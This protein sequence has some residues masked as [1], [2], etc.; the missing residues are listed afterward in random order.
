MTTSNEDIQLCARCGGQCCLTRP[1]I[2]APE[3]FLSNGDLTAALLTALTSGNWV[4][5]EHRGI[6]Y[7]PGLTAPDP[8]RLIRYPRPATVHE[9]QQP[10]FSPLPESGPCVFLMDT[11]CQLLFAERPRLCRELIPDVCFECESPWGRRQAALAWL[12]WQ[13]QVQ[14]VLAGLSSTAKADR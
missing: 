11:G 4:L 9:R 3:R 8:E 12:P 7:E 14:A 13:D 5:E 1:G 2:E 10:G 6:P